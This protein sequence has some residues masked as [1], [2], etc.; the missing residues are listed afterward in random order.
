MLVQFVG[1][2]RKCQRKTWYN[3]D[4]VTI[5]NWKAKARNN[6][7]TL[8]FFLNEFSLNCQITL[9]CAMMNFFS[10]FVENEAECAAT[11]PITIDTPDIQPITIKLI[12]T[13]VAL[14]RNFISK[15]ECGIKKYIVC[16]MT[17]KISNPFNTTGDIV[18]QHH[19]QHKCDE[20][21]FYKLYLM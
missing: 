10:V 20:L 16:N 15:Y 12:N 8:N 9:N 2:V 17:S 1:F 14:C 7:C 18:I 11:S 6:W 3:S 13:G 19:V 5:Q 4:P 21:I